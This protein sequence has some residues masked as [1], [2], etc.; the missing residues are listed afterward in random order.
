MREIL[1]SKI[2]WIIVI[3]VA[4][5]SFIIGIN[6]NKTYQSEVSILFLPKNSA[7]AINIDN[8]IGNA[9]IIS[10]TLKFY[11]S[12][13]SADQGIDDYA[14]ALPANKR[15]EHWQSKI[16]TENIKK[17]NILILRLQDENQLQALLLA[18]QTAW[19]LCQELSQF[20][21]IRTELETRIL[22]EASV[23]SYPSWQNFLRIFIWSISIGFVLPLIFFLVNGLLS[24]SPEPKKRKT[25]KKQALAVTQTLQTEFEPDLD[26]QW[27]PT[28][29]APAPDNLP[30]D[31]KIVFDEEPRE[32]RPNHIYNSL[33]EI[34][35]KNSTR[36][37][38]PEEVKAR[39][40]KLLSGEL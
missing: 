24:F 2:F 40:N 21:N 30:F 18:E 4:T 12:I 29:K 14:E 25:Q 8:I 16:S 22:D 37:A 6:I 15:E 28:K 36:E 5:I 39:L 3:I 23:S 13:L 31:N 32:D 35:K 20:Y 19:S 10:G 33:K 26:E 17:S 7:T 34:T 9:Q 38:T 1:S 11:D 27:S